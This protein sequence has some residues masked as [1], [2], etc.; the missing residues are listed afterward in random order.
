M[1]LITRQLGRV[2]C[3]HGLLENLLVLVESGQVFITDAAFLEVPFLGQVVG[4]WLLLLLLLLSLQDW[5]R[6][7][8]VE[9]NELFDLAVLVGENGSIRFNVSEALSDLVLRD[10]VRIVDNLEVLHSDVLE[11][12]L[13][14]LVMVTDLLGQKSL[15]LLVT[16]SSG[17]DDCCDHLG[18]LGDHLL[19]ITK[20]SQ[21]AHVVDLS[22]HLAQLRVLGAKDG[23]ENLEAVAEHLKLLFQDV[24]CR[25]L[26]LRLIGRFFFRLLSDFLCLGL[27]LLNVVLTGCLV[28]KA[29]HL[30]RHDGIFGTADEVLGAFVITR[31]LGKMVRSV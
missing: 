16:V 21:L 8:D 20:L 10:V 9:T 1:L 13:L 18:N 28:E 6:C 3:K 11:A 19:G 2:H 17:L 15:L 26:G 29:F 5:L 30:V 23:V 24:N 4:D 22:R 14:D 27:V 7:T 25:E 31:I 12:V